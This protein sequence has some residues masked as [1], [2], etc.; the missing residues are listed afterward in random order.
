M[1]LV[2]AGA[3]APTPAAAGG[4]HDDAEAASV[5]EARAVAVLVLTD[6]AGDPTDLTSALADPR[7]ST[8]I[9]TPELDVPEFYVAGVTWRGTE[10][11]DEDISI[12]V[13]SAGRW[14]A[15]APLE[16]E[17][18]EAGGVGGTE[19]YVVGGAT[20]AQV[21]VAGGDGDLP[22]GLRLNLI[23][24]VPHEGEAEATTPDTVATLAERVDT[25]SVSAAPPVDRVQADTSSVAARASGGESFGVS[26]AAT[27]GAPSVVPR[28]GW[29]ASASTPHWTPDFY[30]LR[31]A[32]VHHTAGTNDY[33]RAQSPGI[34]RGIYHYHSTTRGWGDIGYNFLVDKYGQ[35]FEGRNGSLAA[36]YGWMS[37][38]GH[39]AGFNSGTLGIA[40]LGDYTR[41]HAP[42]LVLTRMAE[43][44]AW[45]FA[46]AGIDATTVSGYVSPGSATRPAGQQL[47]RV[48]VH[49][50]VADTTCPGDNI[51]ARVPGLL[52]DV[53]SRVDALGGRPSELH[54][55]N[56]PSGGAPDVSFTLGRSADSVLVGDWDGDG[57]DTPALRRGNRY[58]FYN[59]L[60]SG[61]PDRVVHYGRATDIVLVGDWDG[62]GT[63]TL[64][65]RRGKEYYVKNS[66]TGGN[67]DRVIAYGREWDR[68]LV[69]DWDG[70]GRD[71]FAVRRYSE[72]LVKNSMAGG[73]ADRVFHYGRD[74]DL[75][76]VGDWDGDGSDTMIVRRGSTYYVNNALAGGEAESV[77]AFGRVEDA[78][79]V[80]D[81][82][83]D[84]TDGVGVRRLG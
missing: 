21:R 18:T 29:G 39:A 38:G 23:P 75:V 54:L 66:V 28:A 58:E 78:A 69:G 80:G 11:P 35:V 15:W 36:P 20:G 30:E 41:L 26:A 81:W 2:L 27:T 8:V 7:L 47:A 61:T 52:S 82:D 68:V 16:V 5:D 77:F 43:V 32:V 76:L 67:A 74:S 83:G 13:R 12:R 59:S 50:D 70:D 1:G 22:D 34:V 63:D 31:A 10:V 25:S 14:T 84:G 9:V 40:V 65:V 60:G 48:F 42:Q 45:K 33:S 37:E 19:P 24:A 56:V 3:V 57:V 62:D 51:T 79:L 73:T 44:I 6:D 46:D 71:T 72:Y 53:A 49:R 17:A 64:A 4:E 55:R